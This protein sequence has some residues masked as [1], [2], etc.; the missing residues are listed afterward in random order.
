MIENKEK[1]NVK[2]KE[3]LE[4]KK[5]GTKL[6]IIRIRGLTGIKKDIK[7][8]LNMLNLYRRNYC[9]IVDKNPTYLGMIKKVNHYIS[10]G[11]IDSETLKLLEKRREKT[12]NKEGKEVY[13]KFIR[14]NSPK[15]GYGR[16][17][18]KVPFS[19]GGALG[20][21]GKKINELIK[22]ML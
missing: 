12:K 14:L 11:E 13:K 19:K 8:T 17:G 9:V 10:W 21:R 7:D 16:K 6:A 5:Q 18:I 4:S 2:A 15:K 22:R 1:E 20:Y 3:K